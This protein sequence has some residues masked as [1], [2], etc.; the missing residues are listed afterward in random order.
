MPGPA[1]CGEAGEPRAQGDGRTVRS[2]ARGCAGAR[3]AHL[4]A[5]SASSRAS[6]SASAASSAAR[7]AAFCSGVSPPARLGAVPGD[8]AAAPLAGWAGACG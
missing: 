5:A 2:G 7:R 8:A 3:G 1:A 6:A 4:R